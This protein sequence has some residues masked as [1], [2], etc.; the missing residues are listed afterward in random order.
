MKLAI[1]IIVYNSAPCIKKCI[2]SVLQSILDG[3]A[4]KI[5]LIDNNS[6]DSS[7]EILKKYGNR[8]NFDL[9]FNN[10]NIG[11]AKAAN[12]GIFH[13][14]SNF[15]PDFFFLLNPD[16][17]LGKNCLQKLIQHSKNNRH[18][19]L[20]SSNIIDP[21]T[22]TSWFSGGNIDWFSFKT[23]HADSALQ[24][25]SGCALFIKKEVFFKIGTFD[26][27]FFL[28]YED[29]DFGLRARKAG[30]NLNIVADSICFHI[31]S[32]SS[33]LETKNYHLAKSA[34]FFFH[35]HYPKWALPF[36]WIMFWARFFFHKYF[37]K[38]EAVS[39]GLSDFLTEYKNNS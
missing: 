22:N 6:S 30:F 18:S 27:R 38:K 39:K 32:Q 37:S 34:L 29:A 11:F 23:K 28:Y 21:K 35:K 16:A 5:I 24:Y 17:Y 19:D 13:A 10:K 31:E 1:I 8:E 36:F 2:S 12:Q 4:T 25:L 26:E 15:D 20:A 14:K 7:K 9:I 33:D 3:V